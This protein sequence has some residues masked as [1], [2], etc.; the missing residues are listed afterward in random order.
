MSTNKRA[1]WSEDNFRLFLV[2]FV[3]VAQT[4]LPG[5]QVNPIS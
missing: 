2:V 5:G 4:I 1:I 3:H